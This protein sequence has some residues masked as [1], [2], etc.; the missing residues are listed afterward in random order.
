MRKSLW[1]TALLLTGCAGGADSP[2]ASVPT[3]AP[4]ANPPTG[5]IA[6]G[7]G[8]YQIPVGADATGCPQYTLWSATDPVITVIWYR[9]ADGSFTTD[10]REAHCPPPEPPQNAR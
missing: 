3:T 2:T 9:R 5:A 8:V 1:F 4:T 7:E 6:V 10:R